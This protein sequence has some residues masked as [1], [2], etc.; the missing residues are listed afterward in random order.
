MVDCYFGRA[1]AFK[2]GVYDLSDERLLHVGHMYRPG[3][4]RLARVDHG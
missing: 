4:A 2:S 3:R 1:K